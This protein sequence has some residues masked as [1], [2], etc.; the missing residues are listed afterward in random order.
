MKKTL[1]IILTILVIIVVIVAINIKARQNEE[2]ALRQFNE[3]FEQYLGNKIYGTEV[4]TVINKAIEN[5]KKYNI[6]KD[7]NGF[8]KPDDKYSI[9]VELKMS[10]VDKT[11]Q[12][13][14]F[15]EAGLT[16]FVKNFN[17]VEFE[18]TSIEYH[19]KSGRVS[20]VIFIELPD[21]I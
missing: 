4:T 17:T 6:S 2:K 15:Y 18:C 21:V 9:Q 13:E 19:S 20:K 7:E 3:Q 8:Y 16:E 10:T 11:Y 1:A 5:N 14:Q 12:M